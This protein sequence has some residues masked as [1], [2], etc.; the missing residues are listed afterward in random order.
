MTITEITDL[1]DEP[2]YKDILIWAQNNPFE[3]Y[4]CAIFNVKNYDFPVI[5]RLNDKDTYICGSGALKILSVYIPFVGSYPHFSWESKDIDVF[6]INCDS[7]AVTH[8]TDSIDVVTT[9]YTSVEDLLKSF[10]LSMCRIAINPDG[11]LYV[12]AQALNSIITGYV[13]IPEYAK[14]LGSF[15]MAIMRD[16][17][18]QEVLSEYIQHF[19]EITMY[20]YI[21]YARR[22]EK[23]LNRGFK[24][25]YIE[26]NIVPTY[27]LTRIKYLLPDSI[28][29]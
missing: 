29:H 3:D 6:C 27:I 22:V 26:T 5:P 16:I 20:I 28:K 23:Y 21:N 17:K 1:E 13:H 14:D 24:A 7:S 19:D 25:K 9:T 10:D 8:P 11:E 18:A 4:V 12:T 2:K 15:R